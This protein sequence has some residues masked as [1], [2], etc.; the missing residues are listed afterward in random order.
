[1]INCCSGSSSRIFTKSVSSRR[2][3]GESADT[4]ITYCLSAF[5]TARIL[6]D[7]WCEEE[8]DDDVANS[9]EEKAILD[10]ASS[11]WLPLLSSLEDNSKSFSSTETRLLEVDLVTV[12]L[13]S[14]RGDKSISGNS[15]FGDEFLKV[16]VKKLWRRQVGTSNL[17]EHVVAELKCKAGNGQVWLSCSAAKA[18]CRRRH[19]E[20]R[21]ITLSQILSLIFDNT[22]NWQGVVGVFA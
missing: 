9:E 7:F 13:D 3:I 22:A 1:M 12:L 6:G 2:L 15:F 4:C 11:Y 14:I 16:M 8:S 21:E 17:E 18:I 10:V 19:S 5:S 20:S